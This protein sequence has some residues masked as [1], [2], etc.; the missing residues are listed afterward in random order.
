MLDS[1]ARLVGITTAIAVS[2][3]GAEGLGFAIPIDMA[4][5][6]ANDLIEAGV[7]HHAQLGIQGETALAEADGAEYPVGVRV[8]RVNPGSAYE[9]GEGLVNDVITAIDDVPVSSMEALL[10]D[11][12]T[13]RAGETVSMAVNRSSSPTDLIVVLDERT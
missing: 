3:V 7:V 4:L 10:T 8:T 9:V 1:T 11:L 13:R 12:R 2:D 5:G 6:V